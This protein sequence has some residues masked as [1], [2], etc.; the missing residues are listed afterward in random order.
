MLIWSELLQQFVR[1]CVVAGEGLA[2]FGKC[3]K[4]GSVLLP[5]VK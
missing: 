4:L 3:T 1:V 2:C 5:V